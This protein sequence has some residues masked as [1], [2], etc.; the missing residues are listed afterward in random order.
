MWE[1][2]YVE[3]DRG[4]FEYF[5]KGE[6]NPLCVTHLYSEF[7]S[8]G[9]LFAS[10]FTN[11]YTVYLINLRGC[12]NSTHD[13]TEFN[14]G[15]VDSVRDLEAIREALNIK[16]WTYAGHSTGGMLALQYA[17]M[18]P[19][20]LVKI[21]AGGLC[22]S[23]EYMNHKNSIY[24]RENNQ[25]ARLKEIL[26]VLRDTASTID[27]RRA[28]SKEWTMMSLYNESA[29][30]EMITRPNSGKTVSKR[31]DYF[32]Y[33]ELHTF[34]LRPQLESVNMETHIYAGI[35]DAQCPHECAIEVAELMPN[36]ILTTFEYSNHYP[37]IEEEEP[38]KKFVET[39]L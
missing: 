37:Y 6:G 30:D 12:G 20:N 2:H 18:C 26:A 7:N 38:F 11:L 24:C 3:T 14:L 28:V 23:A 33:K 15:I 13:T 27:E 36:A 8:N 19:E 4:R 5:K 32:S 9:N 10:A 39:T 22:A 21:I 17:I 29:Y 31:L 35:Y 16:E 34:D 1:K 25:N